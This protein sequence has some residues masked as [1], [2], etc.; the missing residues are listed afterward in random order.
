MKMYFLKYFI[1][2][3]VVFSNTCVDDIDKPVITEGTRA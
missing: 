2:A 1:L 3:T